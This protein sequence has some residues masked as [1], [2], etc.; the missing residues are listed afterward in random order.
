M[1]DKA[2][3]PTNVVQCDIEQ[4][5]EGVDCVFRRRFLAMR[6]VGCQL[7]SLLTQLANT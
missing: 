2:E 4:V 7:A 3:Q 1:R 5:A 6:I